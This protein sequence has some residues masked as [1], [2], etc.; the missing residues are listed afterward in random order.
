MNG[1]R[2]PNLMLAAGVVLVA[3]GAVGLKPVL[4]PPPRHSAP[5]VLPA[6]LGEG[7]PVEIGIADRDITAPIVAVGTAG[8]GSL[9]LPPIDEVGW[10]VGGATPA[11]GE[12]TVVLAGHVDDRAG[13]GALYRLD[14]IQPGAVIDVKTPAATTSYSVE[15]VRQYRKQNLPADL[16]RAGGPRRLVVITCGGPF[17]FTTG[18]YRDNLVVIATPTAQR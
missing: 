14:R 7:V 9:E 8:D 4:L 13:P 18:H 1:R 16:F 15:S 12:G 6:S 10:W 2:V 3:V 17:D 11:D 5:A